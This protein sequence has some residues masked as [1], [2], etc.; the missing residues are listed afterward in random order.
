M[1]FL[2]PKGDFDFT[3]TNNLPQ[4]AKRRTKQIR[5]A[6]MTLQVRKIKDTF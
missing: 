3:N 5:E 2:S 6:E 4:G 1:L